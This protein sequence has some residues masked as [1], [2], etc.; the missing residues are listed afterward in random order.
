MRLAVPG[1]YIQFHVGFG[2]NEPTYRMYRFYRH[3]YNPDDFEYCDLTHFRCRDARFAT[4]LP[5]GDVLYQ[6]N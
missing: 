5:E 4:C 6:F 3:N 2:I 1:S